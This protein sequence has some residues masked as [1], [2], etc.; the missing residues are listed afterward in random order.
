[1]SCIGVNY[2]LRF[3]KSEFFGEIARN[4]GNGNAFLSGVSVQAVPELSFAVLYRYFEPQYYSPYATAFSQNTQPSNEYAVYFGIEI[5][6]IK[7]FKINAYADFFRF[8]FLK[9]K[10]SAPSKGKNYFI[11]SAYFLS[12][13]IDL[14]AR[15]T[16]IA[17]QEDAA[18]FAP[19]PPAL[20][21]INLQKA[22]FIISYKLTPSL[23]LRNRIEFT[24]YNKQTEKIQYGYYFSQDLSW[25]SMDNKYTLAGR[26]AF[27]QTDG[28]ESRIYTYENDMLYSYSIPALSGKGIRA[29]LM[30]RYRPIQNVNIWLRYSTTFYS[31]RETIGSGQTQINGNHKSD[32]GLQVIVKF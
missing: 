28:W 6:P 3:R 18:A 17:K 12:E 27:F 1:M 23:R 16:F 8:P 21:D 14:S 11:E 31:D 24:D 19:N 25:I 30:L 22:R 29:Y 26:Y 4:S 20:A 13:D 7:K 10:V 15:Y 32:A 9:Y 5:S 2:L